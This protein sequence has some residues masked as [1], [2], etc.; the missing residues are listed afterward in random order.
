MLSAT[1]QRRFSMHDPIAETPFRISSLGSVAPNSCFLQSSLGE[2]I[3]KIYLED[4]DNPKDQ[5]IGSRSSYPRI[6]IS[7]AILHLASGSVIIF[8]SLVASLGASSDLDDIPH[9]QG[10]SRSPLLHQMLVFVSTSPDPG[11]WLA[12]VYRRNSSSPRHQ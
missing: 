5:W 9:I 3:T 10:M 2:C 12:C 4:S 7:C 8:K 6:D 11:G 1:R